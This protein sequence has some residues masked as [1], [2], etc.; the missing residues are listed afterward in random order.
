MRTRARAFLRIALLCGCIFSALAAQA[1]EAARQFVNPI[2][3]GADP[4]VVRHEGA[5]YWCQTDDNTG[6]AV[7]KS[8]RLTSLGKK[9]AAWKAPETG[10]YAAEIWAPEL[11]RLDGKWYVYTAASDGHNENHRMIVLEADDPLGPFAFKAELYTGDGAATGKQN[12]WAIDGTV[13]EQGGKRYFVWS[14]WEDTRDEQWLYIA[15]MSNP[16]TVSGD[17]VRLCD[18]DDYLWERVS[19]SADERGLHEAPQPLVRDGRTFLVYSCSGSWEPTYKLGMLELRQGGDPLNP[20][21]WSKKPE[22]VFRSTSET[23]GVGHCCF[24][25]SPDGTEDWLAYHAKLER[26]PG[27]HRA[28]YEQPFGWSGDGEPRFG[29]PVPAGKPLPV[30]SGEAE[31]P[32]RRAN[33]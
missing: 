14:G 31:G 23:F 25:K 33:P 2:A 21:D 13:L 27:W 12:R 4:W 7:W 16:W 5:Y 9:H 29:E 22:P 10:P 15:P 19:E 18:N 26:R 6:V 30:P 32:I 11:H 20:K 28:I 3:E 17:R 8:D 1:Q 24:A